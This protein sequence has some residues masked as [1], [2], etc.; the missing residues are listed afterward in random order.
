MR[1]SS[2]IVQHFREY[3][4]SRPDHRCAYFYFTFRDPSKQTCESLVKSLITQ[5]SSQIKQLDVELEKLYSESHL[6]NPQFEPLISTLH[7]LISSFTEIYVII[8][9][10][11]ECT[12]VEKLLS[13]VQT[14]S[15]WGIPGLHL[16]TTSRPEKIITD[17]LNRPEICK[18]P[19]DKVVKNEDIRVHVRAQMQ[20][21]PSL[22]RWSSKP[23]IQTEIE[24]CLVDKA[25]GMQA[26]LPVPDHY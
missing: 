4:K 17:V 16:L 3:C 24:A 8:D 15:N 12:E 10:L 18:I 13:T 19:V 6:S 20:I 25:H 1:L 2:S 23:D 14:I 9:A 5:L 26:S 7:H 21:D 11:D 22:K